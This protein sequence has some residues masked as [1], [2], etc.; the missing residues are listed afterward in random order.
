M[1]TEK[2]LFANRSNA[3]MSTGPR[4]EAGKAKSRYNALKHGLAATRIVIP[5]ENPA[6]YAAFHERLMAEIAPESVLEEDLADRLATTLWRLRRIPHLEN[7]YFA[8][9]QH[10][11]WWHD[12]NA[13]ALDEDELRPTLAVSGEAS[14]REEEADEH[15]LE[16]W[17]GLKAKECRTLKLIGRTVK[18]ARGV[19]VKLSA[20]EA[21]LLRQAERLLA[22]LR[23]LRAS[24]D[25]ARRGASEAHIVE[26]RPAIAATARNGGST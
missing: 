26:A 14:E 4:T 6:D 8:W 22:Q 9:C 18:D 16:T 1:A 19:L 11:G 24:R 13:S 7:A 12:A 17:P 3:L 20:Y 21:R 5:G 2:Q 10:E 25:D 23:Q 15:T